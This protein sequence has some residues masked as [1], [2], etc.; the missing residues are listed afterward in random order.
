[1]KEYIYFSCLKCAKGY[2]L[3]SNFLL[4][5][6]QCRQCSHRF[7]PS[8]C[9]DLKIEKP[10][11][12]QRTSTKTVR[13]PDPQEKPPSRLDKLAKAKPARSISDEPSLASDPELDLVLRGGP[14]LW[15]KGIAAF[16]HLLVLFFWP[17]MTSGMWPRRSDYAIFHGILDWA[18]D[19]S[20]FCVPLLLLIL[21]IRGKDSTF[22]SRHVVAIFNYFF[23]S[24]L[25]FLLSCLGFQIL[26][27]LVRNNRDAVGALFLIAAI[28]LVTANLSFTINSVIA[29]S[30]AGRGK[31]C[32]YLLTFSWI[33]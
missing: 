15:E 7:V 30:K 27:L 6:V 18:G 2:R 24:V 20:R 25:I 1:M 5:T 29:A 12:S 3:D 14:E 21:L 26:F 11:K 8:S 31:H 13:I 33:K 23:S 17:A 19:Y 4:Q 9:P 32:Q 22:L 10:Q 16:C 28:L